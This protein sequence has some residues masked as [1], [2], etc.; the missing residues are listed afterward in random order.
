MMNK[1]YLKVFQFINKMNNEI[2]KVKSRTRKKKSSPKIIIS[3]IKK[4]ITKKSA[5]KVKTPL[6][7]IEGLE[8]TLLSK[9]NYTPN[10]SESKRKRA[11]GNAVI[12]YD[13]KGLNDILQNL[14]SK[15]AK[16]KTV[17]DILKKDSDF[18][19]KTYYKFVQ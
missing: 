17:T 6:S 11:L 3:S 16:N 1:K 19:I 14:I 9:Y 18:V 13:P 7:K 4:S 8:N 12:V 10:N 5:N 2:K 15:N